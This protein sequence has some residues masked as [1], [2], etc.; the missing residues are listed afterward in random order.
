[1][2]VYSNSIQKFNDDVDQGIIASIVK[3]ELA[4]RNIINNILSEFFSWDKSVFQMRNILFHPDINQELTV[5]IEYQI[6]TT[7]KRVD[8][9]SIQNEYTLLIVAME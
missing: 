3:D 7:S 2:I 8:F 5:A 6:P 9:I 4:K 1:M